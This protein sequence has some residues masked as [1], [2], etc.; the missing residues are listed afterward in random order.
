M[1]GVLPTIKMS[2]PGP[3]LCILQID[4]KF[5]CEAGFLCSSCVA[6]LLKDVNPTP[7]WRPSAENTF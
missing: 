3:E 7:C 5:A 6:W 1:L 2:Y 4:G